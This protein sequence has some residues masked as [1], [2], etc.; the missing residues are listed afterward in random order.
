MEET[1]TELIESSITPDK[2]ENESSFTNQEESGQPINNLNGN[3]EE[4]SVNL[5]TSNEDKYEEYMENS[6]IEDKHCL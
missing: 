2:F 3:I 1:E 5:H 4:S 6:N